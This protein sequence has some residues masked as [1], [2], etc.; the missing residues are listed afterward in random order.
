M[1]KKFAIP[2]LIAAGLLPPQP[3]GALPDAPKPEGG[4]D[5]PSLFK[6]FT[7]EHKYILA[8][9]RSHSSHGSHRSSS[10]GGYSVPSVPRNNNSTPPSSVLP[11]PPAA[12][13][14]NYL[15]PPAPPPSPLPGNTNKFKQIVMEVQMALLAYGYY[16]GAI[17]G[18]VGPETRTA[19]SKLQSDYKLKITGTVTPEVLDALHVTAR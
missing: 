12:S 1:K 16:T 9:H 11:S 7:L 17:D 2:S 8:G 18:V 10:G 14:P 3:V 19:I 4:S 5:R 15:L 6:L 13:R